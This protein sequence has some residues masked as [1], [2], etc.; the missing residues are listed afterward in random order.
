MRLISDKKED[1]KKKEDLYI[2]FTDLY[3]N[4]QEWLE[5]KLAEGHRIFIN[6]KKGRV[7]QVSL[8]EYR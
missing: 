3:K 8:V 7:L 4:K 1:D 6:P 5:S 2:T